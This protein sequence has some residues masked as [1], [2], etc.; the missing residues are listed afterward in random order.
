[1]SLSL[2]NVLTPIWPQTLLAF[3]FFLSFRAHK[4]GRELAPYEK[5]FH[6]VELESK[7]LHYCKLQ[8]LFFLCLFL[9][10]VKYTVIVIECMEKSSFSSLW[11]IYGPSPQTWKE[12][13]QHI[14]LET[15]TSFPLKEF[16]LL[17]R[18]FKFFF[19]LDFPEPHVLMCLKAHKQTDLWF[20]IE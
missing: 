9:E 7:V 3:F 5:I 14:K 19:F 10:V 13:K 20:D 1:M 18:E 12:D 8:F 11:L 6:D 2:K 17:I 15:K 16:I 4:F